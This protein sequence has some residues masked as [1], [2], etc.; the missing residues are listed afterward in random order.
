MHTYEQPCM[1]QKTDAR[2]EV[3]TL[4]YA[5]IFVKNPLKSAVDFFYLLFQSSTR[6]E[7]TYI[8]M[9]VEK[10]TRQLE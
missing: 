5:F 4:G 7:N 8:L 10:K 3:L 2:F 1:Y 6:S 9:Y